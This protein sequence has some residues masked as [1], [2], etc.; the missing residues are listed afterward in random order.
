MDID[1]RATHDRGGDSA[2]RPNDGTDPGPSR[3]TSR[4]R[5]AADSGSVEANQRDDE[6][7]DDL[8]ERLA[9]RRDDDFHY[10]EVY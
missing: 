10:N 2:P 1:E 6:P 8:L 4:D 7:R 5:S 3:E 9:M